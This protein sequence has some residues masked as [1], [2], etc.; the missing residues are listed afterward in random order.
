MLAMGLTRFRFQLRTML[1]LIGALA[2][3][4]SLYLQFGPL[5]EEARRARLARDLETKMR[6]VDKLQQQILN[7]ERKVDATQQKIDAAKQKID[8]LQKKI[9]ENQKQIEGNQ[10]KI[11]EDQPKSERFE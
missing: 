11:D 6:S 9:D 10:L 8:E 2:A 4:L 5:S 7:A 1:I 3:L